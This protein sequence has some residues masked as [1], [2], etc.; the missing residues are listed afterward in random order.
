MKLA[1]LIQPRVDGTVIV[2]GDDGKDYVFERDADGELVCDVD[3][4][5]TA[6]ALLTGGNF[7]PADA[8]DYDAA[9][10][11]TRQDSQG[12][13]QQSEGDGDGDDDE[14]V[15]GGM[16]VEADSPLKPLPSAAANG[17]PKKAK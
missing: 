10:S 9:L 12:G 17:K 13:D 8:G 15:N 7:Y 1:T 3:H 5:G 11:L 2:H 16:P 6:S 14:I 4:E